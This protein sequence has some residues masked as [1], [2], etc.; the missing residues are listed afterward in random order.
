[1]LSL[2][3]WIFL[4]LVHCGAFTIALNQAVVIK[5]LIMASKRWKGIIAYTTNQ[6]FRDEANIG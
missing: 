6:Y 1:M 3:F 2:F 5:N 4:L